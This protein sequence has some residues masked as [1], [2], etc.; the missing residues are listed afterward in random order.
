MPKVKMVTPRAC[1]KAAAGLG[2]PP[3]LYP[4][5]TRNTALRALLRARAST[6]CSRGRRKGRRMMGGKVEG[7]RR[8]GE[9]GREGEEEYGRGRSERREGGGG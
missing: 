8:K 9:R 4:S 7:V 1:R 3:L 2:S 5:V 6:L